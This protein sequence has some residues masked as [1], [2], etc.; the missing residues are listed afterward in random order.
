[1]SVLLSN[2]YR[3]L[4][5]LLTPEERKEVVQFAFKRLDECF[6]TTHLAEH[7]LDHPLLFSCWCY[8]LVAQVVTDAPFNNHLYQDASCIVNYPYLCYFGALDLLVEFEN[9]KADYLACTTF[10]S[11][12]VAFFVLILVSG[13]PNLVLVLII[14]LMVCIT[15][16]FY[17]DL[18]Y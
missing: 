7:S 12:P 1:M 18:S 8:K 2:Q 15:F 3:R 6:I 4:Y 10:T 5:L 17:L 11:R 13:S 9:K 16:C 14:S